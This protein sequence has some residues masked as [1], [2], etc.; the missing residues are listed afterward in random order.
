MYQYITTLDLTNH[1]SAPMS[2]SSIIQLSCF[3]SYKE[4]ILDEQIE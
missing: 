2:L 4:G 3:K 1:H